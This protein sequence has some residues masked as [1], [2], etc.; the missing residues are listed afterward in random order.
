MSITAGGSKQNEANFHASSTPGSEN[1]GKHMTAD[2]V[3]DFFAPHESTSDAV[4]EWLVDSGIGE[5]RLAISVNKQV[6]PLPHLPD[7][8]LQGMDAN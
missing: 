6:C 5:D 3:I 7:G 4:M 8:L 2:E 1:Y